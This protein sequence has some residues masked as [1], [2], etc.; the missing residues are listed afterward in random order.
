MRRLALAALL[1][2]LPAPPAR[3]AELPVVRERLDNGFTVLV[4]SNPSAPVVAVSVLVKMGT[5]W[6]TAETAGISNYVQAVIVK[7]TTRHNGGEI[8][9]L[10]TDLGGKLSA[11]GN[12]DYSEIRGTALARFWRQL[13]GL[14][15]ELALEPALKPDQV[16]GERDLLLAR[17]QKREDNPTTHAFDAVF[18]RLSGAH[19]YGL[20]ILGTR[21]SLARID[22]AAVA[23]WYRRFYRP[24]RMVLAVSGQVPVADVV[25]EAR[26]LFGGLPAG[27]DGDLDRP[28]PPPTP[29]GGRT[30]IEQAAQQAHVLMGSLAPGVPDADY[31]AVKVL[32]T[33]LGGGLAGRLFVELRDRQALAYTVSAFFDPV[34]G[35]GAFVVYMGTAPENA[36]RAEQ[37]LAREIERIRAERVS[38]AE[39]R[40]AKAYLL[41]TFAMDR[42]TNARQAFYLAFFEVLGVG[43]DFPVRY[44][45]AVEAVTADDLLRVARA[46]LHPLTTVVVEPPAKR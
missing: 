10:I 6:E 18:A 46:Y 5:R 38:D 15:A 17:A 26:R 43:Y 33:V 21:E 7:G 13:L 24:G 36:A 22:R 34:R 9:E 27:S 44:R 45:A 12:T 42:R 1:C 28:L 4:R 8:A 16:E 23:A 29:A 3:G 14:T 31:A 11:N 39:L 2:L 32:G 37:A 20:P 40:R 30:V 41:G 19:P 35:P 25:A